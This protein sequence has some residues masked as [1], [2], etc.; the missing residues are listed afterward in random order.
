MADVPRCAEAQELA[1]EVALGI[2][3]AEDRARLLWHVAECAACRSLLSELSALTDSMLALTPEQEP[4]A[5]F[6]TQVLA[7]IGDR[8]PRRRTWRTW[9]RAAIFAVA[10]AIA[11]AISGG[12]VYLA[13]GPDRDL[14][15]S[16]RAT[17]ATGDG[18]YFAAAPLHDSRGE[19][20]GVAFGYQG[21][22]A[23][24]FVTASVPAPAGPYTIEVVTHAGVS[25]LLAEDVDLAG[26]QA[27]GGT[28]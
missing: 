26:T 8:T 7:R 14:A 13:H 16:V 17:L 25:H 9:R 20:Q 6:E 4:P 21:D 12:A 3:P 19:R 27:W 28:T 5:G 24:V 23:W 1:P 18:Q 15:A 11:A 10:V 2:A 22:P